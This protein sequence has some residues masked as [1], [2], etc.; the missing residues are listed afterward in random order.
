M[1]LRTATESQAETLSRSRQ[2]LEAT[3]AFIARYREASIAAVA[4][5]LVAYIQ[6]N[7]SVFLSSPLMSVVTRDT[8]RIGMIAAGIVLVMIT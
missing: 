3:L 2:W 8:A 4:V 6:I 7:N 5:L 1:A